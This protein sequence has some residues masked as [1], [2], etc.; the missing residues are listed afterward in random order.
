[1]EDDSEMMT[2]SVLEKLFFFSISKPIRC[3]EKFACEELP[4]YGCA[5][6]VLFDEIFEECC[7]FCFLAE[8]ICMCL[9][10]PLFCLRV[11]E[12]NLDK[13][14]FLRLGDWT[15]FRFFPVLA[16]LDVALVVGLFLR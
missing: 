6:E 5:T 10:E 14:S 7:P 12:M 11:G 8:L 3:D 9:V 1:M 13:T 16:T 2:A 15:F 4:G